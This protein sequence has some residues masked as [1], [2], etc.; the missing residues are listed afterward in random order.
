MKKYILSTIVALS[1]CFTTNAQIK[2]GAA[3]SLIYDYTQPGVHGILSIDMGE[4]YALFTDLGFHLPNA[5]FQNSNKVS[6]FALDLGLHY[7]V[8][9]IGEEGRLDGVAGIQLAQH[10][11]DS[12][13]ENRFYPGITSGAFVM[14]PINDS[15]EAFVEVKGVIGGITQNYDFAGLS[16]PIA[17]LIKAGVFF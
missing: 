14:Y 17:V 12:D 13:E 2:F 10:N 8:I 3:A 11:F 9:S 15:M 4:R 7:K 16:D 1:F 6:I 5:P